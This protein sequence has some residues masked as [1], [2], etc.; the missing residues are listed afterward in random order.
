RRP[1]AHRDADPRD[2]R[3]GRPLAARRCD[4]DVRADAA[5]VGD[6]RVRAD[7]RA[8]PEPRAG[9]PLP[10]PRSE[11]PQ[12]RRPAAPAAPPRPTADPLDDGA[13]SV[14][15][16]AAVALPAARR[17]GRTA[18][19]L[20]DVSP[21]ARGNAPRVHPRRWPARAR[22]RARRGRRA[23]RRNGEWVVPG[24]HPRARH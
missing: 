15:E 17:R 21:P 16:L 3:G 7:A 4:P 22:S 20:A 18:E 8:R 23:A 11:L 9:L 5:A 10:R 2:D 1:P 14:A 6:T 12:P 19:R 13:R 24:G